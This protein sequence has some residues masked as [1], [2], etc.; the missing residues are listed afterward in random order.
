ME[1]AHNKN[2]KLKIPE[3]EKNIYADHW[4]KVEKEK[5]LPTNC[6]ELKIVDY[7]EFAAKIVE[8][9]P[10]F[11]KSV[12]E[13][14]YLGD[15]YILKNALDNKEVSHII[16][17]IH[18]FNKSTPSKFYK[19]LENVPNFHRWIG[20]DLINNYTIKYTKHPTYMFNW[21]EDISDVRKIIMKVCKP[22]KLLAGL[23]MNEFINHTPKDLIV[24]RLQIT[25]YPPTGFIEP[26]VDANSLIRLIISGYLS[27]RGVD[28]S[29][30]GFYFITTDNKK[31]DI[32]SKIE[33]GDVG[34]FYGCLRHGLEIIDPKKTPDVNKKDGR[35]W[36]GLNVH[37]SD[38]MD[39]SK[40]ITSQPYSI[41][42]DGK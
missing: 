36:F 3:I 6:R 16:D 21:N 30:G 2:N 17:E 9:D 1:N 14:I 39:S 40:R 34:F 23:S 22:L 42:K 31:I 25:R 20:K 4:K 27:T 13:S 5:G 8:Q 19:M 24:E 37:N 18:K 12:I 26:H 33:A 10:N 15:Y 32:E 41:S 7:K 29:E 28:Y 11:V 38:E 35:W